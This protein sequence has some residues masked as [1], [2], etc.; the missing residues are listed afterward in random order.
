M[1]FMIQFV[2]TGSAV[3]AGKGLRPASVIV[4]EDA[5]PEAHRD[6][7]RTEVIGPF[8]YADGTVECSC[9]RRL[10]C[11]PAQSGCRSRKASTC[12]F[13]DRKPEGHPD[14]IGP[15][16]RQVV[17]EVAGAGAQRLLRTDGG[18]FQPLV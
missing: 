1:N 2:S 18:E 15:V 8:E 7:L 3:V 11:A 13:A 14:E 5:P 9:Q 6:R 17:F 4:I 12:G 16:V 10:Q